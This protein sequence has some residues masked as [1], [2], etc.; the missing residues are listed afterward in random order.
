MLHYYKMAGIG[1][2]LWLSG[3]VMENKGES[4]KISGSLPSPCK[5]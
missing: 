4:K 5:L 3:W 2:P 1:E